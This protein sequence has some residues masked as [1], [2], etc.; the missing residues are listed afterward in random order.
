MI[1]LFRSGGNAIF[2]QASLYGELA[3]VDWAEEK[4]RLTNM[5]VAGTA[6]FA[7]LLSLLLFVGV[8]VLAL[9]WDTTY[10]VPAVVAM[11]M[12]YA[13]GLGVAWFRAR[14]LLASGEQA[15]AAMRGELAA[16]FTFIKI[17]KSK[18]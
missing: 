11:I 6:A 7:C 8:L 18:L 4:K 9:S 17:I 14:A 1:R 16:D 15:F 13:T 2:G 10:R 3:R 5:F 12:L